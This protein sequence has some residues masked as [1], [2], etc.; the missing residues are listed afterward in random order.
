MTLD[1]EDRAWISS[2]IRKAV[3]PSAEVAVLPRLTFIQFGC[4]VELSA[5]TIAR[6]CR[7]REIPEKFVTNSRPKK[8]SAAALALFNVTP[9]EA[10]ARLAARNL[11]PGEARSPEQST[12][13]PDRP[14]QS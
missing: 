3:A 2:E 5:D 14:A 12:G 11:L 7:L 13:R 4:A 6:K 1:A 8:I 9:Q 10:R